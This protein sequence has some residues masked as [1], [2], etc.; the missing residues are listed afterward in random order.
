[1]EKNQYEIMYE[2]EENHFWFKGMRN[3]TKT[4]LNKY[5]PKTKKIKILDAGCGTGGALLFL[6]SYGETKGIDISDYAIKLCKKR[7]FKNVEVGSIDKLPYPGDSFDLVTCFDVIGQQEVS[8]GK[9][10]I[11][12]FYRVLKPGGILLLRIAAY[13]W[14]LSPHDKSLHTKHR[15]DANELTSILN[16]VKFKPL[17]TTYANCLLFPGVLIRRTLK[18]LFHSNNNDNSD[19]VVSINPMLNTLFKIPFFIE[20]KLINFVNLPFGL[21][22]ITIARKKR[23]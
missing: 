12:E 9:K 15:Y 13:N 17:K 7:G 8:S 19:L 2:I 4:L 3:I 10:A 14:L 21:S 1:M 11:Q 18:K 5:L 20:N 23:N 16:Q 22:V 6:K